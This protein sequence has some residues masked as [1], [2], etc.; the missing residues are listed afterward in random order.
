MSSKIKEQIKEYSNKE[1]LIE[2]NKDLFY[3]A[4]EKNVLNKVFDE[5]ENIKYRRIRKRNSSMIIILPKE[6]IVK[7]DFRETKKANLLVDE[8]T[9]R[10]NT[11]VGINRSISCVGGYSRSLILPQG[12]A[13][14]KEIL[15]IKKKDEENIEISK[16]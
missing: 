12:F 15:R 14:D 3:K 11:K 6:I 10:L 9:I 4:F 1:E 16:L 13:E 5:D 8:K 7:T 2:K